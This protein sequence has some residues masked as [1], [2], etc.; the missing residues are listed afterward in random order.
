MEFKKNVLMTDIN[1][2]ETRKTYIGDVSD[3]RYVFQPSIQLMLE[4]CFSSINIGRYPVIKRA[5]FI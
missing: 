1:Y 3:I 5:C 2:P 4:T